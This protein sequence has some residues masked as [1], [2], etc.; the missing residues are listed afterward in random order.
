LVI[1]ICYN[2]NKFAIIKSRRFFKK[3]S[4]GQKPSTDLGRKV[5][6]KL[7]INSNQFVIE[8]VREYKLFFKK[9]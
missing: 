6:G 7:K 5:G 3:N 2:K 1:I 9:Y 8:L 4:T